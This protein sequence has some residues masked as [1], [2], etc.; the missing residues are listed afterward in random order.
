MWLVL[1]S[2]TFLTLAAHPNVFSLTGICESMPQ[3]LRPLGSCLTN[4][5]I[6]PKLQALVEAT[7][8]AVLGHQTIAVPAPWQALNRGCPH[9]LWTVNKLANIASLCLKWLTWW[10]L[11]D[12][13][14]CPRR[15]AEAVFSNFVTMAHTG[16]VKKYNSDKALGSERRSNSGNLWQA[17]KKILA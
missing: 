16:V 15:E 8:P 7:R 4:H 6:H 1:I 3:R 12:I 5:A 14:H 13:L 10:S 11:Y 9:C 17:A 2:P